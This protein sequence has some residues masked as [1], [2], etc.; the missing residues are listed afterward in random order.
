MAQSKQAAEII[1]YLYAASKEELE[2]MYKTMTVR[3]IGAS[4]S[5][6]YCCA[7]KRM[8]NLGIQLFGTARRTIKL[9]EISMQDLQ[10]MYW[11]NNKTLGDIAKDYGVC[12]NA[13]KARFEELGIKKR[14]YSERV[15]LGHERTSPQG[16]ENRYV[17]NMKN[18]IKAHQSGRDEVETALYNELQKDYPDAV[19]G[20]PI[21]PYFADITIPSLDL[22]IEVD[23]PY[24]RSR[25]SKIRQG[26]D[27]RQQ[28]IE[29]KGWDVIRVSHKDL[30]VTKISTVKLRDFVDTLNS[31]KSAQPHKLEKVS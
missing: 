30:L 7:R 4:F 27:V 1:K 15:S 9:R 6:S 25:G 10:Q 8:V 20:F 22:V 12:P 23:G 14:D 24:H 18:L 5:V 13:V 26:D 28:F 16:V 21:G 11:G 19:R 31:S 3:E 29:S 2:Q 17:T